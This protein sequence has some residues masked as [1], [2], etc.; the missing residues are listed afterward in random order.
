MARK[1]K[2]AAVWQPALTK[3]LGMMVTLIV[4]PKAGRLRKIPAVAER[5]SKLLEQHGLQV[6]PII[7]A[8]GA[9]LREAALQA[10]ESGNQTLV[11]AGGDGTV[12]A[13]ASVMLDSGASLG[14]LPMGTL[15]H[16][17]KDLQIPL[18]LEAAAQT[19]AAGKVRVIDVGDVNGRTFIN[20]SSLGIYPRFVSSREREQQSGR[21]KW[22][23]FF[24]AILAAL[25]QVSCLKVRLVL[26]SK[27]IARLTPL[28]FIGNNEYDTEGHGRGTRKCLDAGKLFICVVD[29]RSG[30][31]L[32]GLSLRALFGHLREVEEFEVFRAP[33]AWIETR[34]HTVRVSFDGEVSRM[35][36]PLHYRIRPAALR[37]LAP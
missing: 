31:E 6:S 34:R 33:E 5:L 18:S 19:I 12:S 17:A 15:N 2:R 3:D 25:R 37:V 36:T 14:I 8:R 32:V 24:S 21:S 11:V 30:I 29:A 10:L 35:Q 16:F 26:G 13:V 20:N 27:V 1:A 23:A 28:I 9:K 4:N 7:V 22:F